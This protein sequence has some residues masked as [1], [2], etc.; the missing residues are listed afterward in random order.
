ML[1][2]CGKNTPRPLETW[3][4]D[5]MQPNSTDRKTWGYLD[6]KIALIR[7]QATQQTIADA[8][9]CDVS[10]VSHILAGREYGDGPKGRK[11]KAHIADLIGEPVETVFPE[12]TPKA[13]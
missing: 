8:C 13:A 3:C 10:L 11:V 4:N 1:T 2:A 6:R 12:Q 5:M 9:E 7:V